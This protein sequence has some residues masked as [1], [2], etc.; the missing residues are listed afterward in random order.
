MISRASASACAAPPMSFFISRMPAGRLEVEAAAVEAD[1][2]ADD[3]DARMPGLPHSS[4]IRRG[5]RSAVAAAADRGDQRIAARRARRRAVTRTCAPER[6]AIVARRPASSS[7]G[8]RSAAGVLT[9]SRTRAVASAR[10]TVAS[11]RAGFAGQQDARP[12]FGLVGLRAVS[13]EAMLGEQPAERGGARL[14][15]RRACRCL[16]A[17]SR[18]AWRGTRATA[19]P[20]S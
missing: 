10:R 16:R 11:I 12:A 15:R 13:V 1:A 18:R 4:S 5:A 3:R 8:P 9:R 2:L 6:L 19:R 7:A 14:A 20:R 17:G